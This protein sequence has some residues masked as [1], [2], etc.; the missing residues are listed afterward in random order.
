MCV[1][2]E[3][4][5]NELMSAARCVSL[6][7]LVA[8]RHFMDEL[9]L[10]SKWL[11]RTWQTVRCV[12]TL[13]KSRM[14]SMSAARCVSLPL[15]LAEPTPCWQRAVSLIT[16]ERWFAGDVLLSLGARSSSTRCPSWGAPRVSPCFQHSKAKKWQK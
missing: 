2:V 13:R 11:Q 4:P 16:L 9:W 1:Y 10:C 15:L 3:S 7:F 5:S 12:F 8:A 14:S 6:P